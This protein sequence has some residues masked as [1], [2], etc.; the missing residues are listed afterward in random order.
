M[1]IL[2]TGGAGYVG[3]VLVNMLLEQG[4]HV[5]VV[6][7]LW[8]KQDIPL[9]HLSNPNYHF[10]RGDF[11]DKPLI[12]SLLKG[13]DFVFHTAAI[14]GE[15]ASNKFPELTQ[16]TNYTD[17]VQ[18]IEACKA[19]QVKGFIFLS[20]CSNYGVASQLAT[21]DTPLKPLSPYADTKVKIEQYLQQNSGLNWVIGRLST[22]YGVSPR[23]RFDLTVNDFALKGFRDKYIDIFLPE[24]YRPYI[25]VFDLA[26]VLTAILGQ[27]DGLKNQVFNIGFEGENYQKIRIAKAVQAKI[28]EVNIDIL[29][30]GGDTRDYQV[31]FSKLQRFMTIKN[32]FTVE[33]SV[34]EMLNMLSMRLIS[35]PA[36]PSYYNTTPEMA[37]HV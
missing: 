10:V 27:F 21:E 5:T 9:A 18:L 33:K 3:S 23:M 13:V 12:D 8:F 34:D 7:V 1:K 20:T 30:E 19:N 11:G 31:D 22:V 36:H 2:V 6:D 28:P 17:S 16:K 4:H 37:L 25:H 35:D 26:R 32:I 24:S 14:V 29:R 15:P